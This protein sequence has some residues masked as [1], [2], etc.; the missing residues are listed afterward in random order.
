MISAYG[1]CGKT[2]FTVSAAGE[3]G[4]YCID[5]LPSVSCYSVGGEQCMHFKL[6]ALKVLFNALSCSAQQKMFSDA[7]AGDSRLKLA[8]VLSPAA[9]MYLVLAG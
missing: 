1:L 9:L 4:Q 2:A 6:A 3:G 7:L 5:C 8:I